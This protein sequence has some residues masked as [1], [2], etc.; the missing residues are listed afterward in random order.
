MTDLKPVIRDRDAFELDDAKRRVEAFL[1]KNLYLTE[2][3]LN[4]LR[5]FR[6][7]RYKPE[8]L[9]SDERVLKRIADHPMALWKTQRNR[10]KGER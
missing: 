9:C 2:N 6:Q 3:D 10:D 4:F 7:G 1:D 5:D 8:N